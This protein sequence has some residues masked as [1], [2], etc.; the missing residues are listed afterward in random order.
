LLP[1]LI[2]DDSLSGLTDGL[3]VTSSG[4][5]ATLEFRSSIQEALENIDSA[6]DTLGGSAGIG[7]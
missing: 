4:S 3:T 7:L 6:A 2:G 5:Q 1:N